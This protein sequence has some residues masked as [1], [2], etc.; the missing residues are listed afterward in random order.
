MAPSKESRALAEL[1]KTFGTAFPA[2]GNPYLSRCVYDQVHTVAS[3][4]QGVGFYIDIASGLE[5]STER[6]VCSRSA[7]KASRQ[8]IVR[9]FG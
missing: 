4:A 8:A 3:E 2:D 1:F 7:T 6:T 9:V 5:T